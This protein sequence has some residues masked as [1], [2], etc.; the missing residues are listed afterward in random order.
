MGWIVRRDE[1]LIFYQ[2]KISG[3]A[4]RGEEEGGERST[5]L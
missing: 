3:R 5:V 1:L 4:E 2:Q